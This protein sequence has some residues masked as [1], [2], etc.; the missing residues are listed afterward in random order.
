MDSHS[1]G[2][3]VD[4]G[5]R[6]AQDDRNHVL[7]PWRAQEGDRGPII[8]H[9]EG[10][11]FWDHQ[12][13][14]YLDFTSQFVFS[15]FGHGERRV[16]HAIQRQ[17]ETLPVVASQFVTE[18]RSDAAR[19]IAE[20]TPGDLDR[21]FF[22]TSGA[23]ANEAAIKMARD[24]TGRPLICTRYRSYHGST[25]G[26]MTLS[27]DPRSWAFEPGIPGVIYAPTCDPYRCRH[28]PP[29]GRHQDCG[30]HCARELEE[31][32][33]QNAPE[34]VA[35]VIL[36]PIVGA[37]GVIVPADGYLQ[38]VRRICDHYGI[39][40]IADEVMTGFGRTGR[41]FACEHWNVTPDIMT[42]AKGMSGGYVPMAATVVRAPLATYWD[43][44]KL[45]H[46][47]TYSGH[48]LGCAATTASIQV[49]REDDLIDRSA[50][51]GEYL[52]AGAQELMERHACVG[53]VRGKGLFVG[54]ELV[55]NRRT[56]EPFVDQTRVASGPTTKNRVIS[57]AMDDGVYVMAGQASV[58]TLSPPLTVTREQIDE[59]LDVLDRALVLADQ[60]VES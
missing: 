5:T 41:W 56:K 34:R 46:G 16:V 17:A 52:L 14:R 8:T 57:K 50:R 37:N 28:A 24:V 58:I 30:E 59:G 54:M 21:V 40:L 26:A 11:Y 3:A 25:F 45:V 18:A 9:A 51:S 4:S 22:T 2:T 55:R 48:T 10:V 43:D 23:E 1:R 27:R 35:A 53:D 7:V 32:L 36:E 20:V 38:E 33:L 60:E 6:T 39:V 31:V 15:N 19:A 44:H 49:Y 13:R 29:A 12:G 42:V 47:H